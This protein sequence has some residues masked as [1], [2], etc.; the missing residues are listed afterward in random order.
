MQV[1]H[2]KIL[3]VRGNLTIKAR[4]V[5]YHSRIRR[6][7]LVFM[8]DPTRSVEQNVGLTFEDLEQLAKLLGNYE[9]ELVKLGI[10]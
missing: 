7:E 8:V 2:E 10:V 6:T 4:N 9:E 3:A 1:F 5:C